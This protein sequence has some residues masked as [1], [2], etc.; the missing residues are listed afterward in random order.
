MKQERKI[1]FTV[2]CQRLS[3]AIKAPVGMN[4]LAILMHGWHKR[5][6]DEAPPFGTLRM[7]KKKDGYPWLTTQEAQLLGVYAGYKIV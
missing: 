7:R 1:P 4:H 5:H 3:K 2:I 6:P